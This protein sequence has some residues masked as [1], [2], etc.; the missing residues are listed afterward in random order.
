[1]HRHVPVGIWNRWRHR[2]G[3]DFDNAIFDV[4]FP[5]FSVGIHFGVSPFLLVGLVVA[6]WIFTQWVYRHTIPPVAIWKRTVLKIVRVLSLAVILL[7]LWK[8]VLS[9][10]VEESDAP[11]VAILVD[12]SA[13]MGLEE[14]NGKRSD[15][16]G[17]LFD[18]PL[19]RDLSRRFDLRYF[20]FAD[21][22]RAV[23]LEYVD[24]LQY[25]RTGSNIAGAWNQVEKVLREEYYSA[26][27]VISDGNNNAG[28]NPV[29]QAQYSSVPLFTV[30]IGDTTPARDAMIVQVITNDICYAGDE[31]PV[32]VR[33]RGV[34][35]QG[36]KS[37]LTFSGPAGENLGTQS[38]RW[39]EDYH[40]ETVH[41][42]FT[43]GES[44]TWKYEVLLEPL[45]DEL[46]IHNNRKS[47]Y[48]K[49]LESKVR[50]FVLS[51][52]PSFDLDF[53]IKCLH[54]NPRVSTTLRT[55]RSGGGYYEGA[56]PSVNDLAQ[57]DLMILHHYPTT[58]TNLDDLQKIAEVYKN[59]DIPILFLMGPEVSLR[60][61]DIVS[62]ILPVRPARFSGQTVELSC[63]GAA[64]HLIF[65]DDDGRQW[66]KWEALPPLWGK[67][68][69][70]TVKQGSQVIGLANSQIG[71]G[72][73]PGIVLRKAG[74]K[75]SMAV[76][77]WGLWRWGFLT[78]PEQSKTLE[79]FLDRSI[80]YL[81]TREEDKQVRFTTSKPIYQGGEMVRLSAQ[82]YSED[83]EPVDGAEVE[84]LVTAGE[85]TVR[86][87]MDGEGNGRYS[88]EISA[89]TEGEYTY[90]GKATRD[91][92]LGE[93][94]GKFTVEAFNIEF[95]NT[96]MN[97]QLLRA[98]AT[99]SGGAYYAPEAIGEI[100]E[101]LQFPPRTSTSSWE[102]PIWNRAWLLWVL[103][104][105]LSLEWLIRKRSGML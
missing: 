19:W 37:A 30:G 91:K 48:I 53:F 8:P 72:P 9:I 77:P 20:A 60:K 90:T 11:I 86:L 2:R 13:S 81:V 6:A 66:I 95:L 44:G 15:A 99:L 61:L 92:L 31:V 82:V 51:G 98:V 5:I 32:D 38:V 80:R 45:S 4:M 22:V 96:T 105:L 34:G 70:F 46:T 89:W 55:Q 14:G 35:I 78:S 93:D 79:I 85:E 68:D 49:V 36:E 74:W 40:E 50:V 3:F 67:H 56:F 18:N 23:S 42:T 83:Y 1:M 71:G 59:E 52:A 25:D 76:L 43:P 62:D 63:N 27:V 29:R 103:V 104:G 39:G 88:G 100:A 41:L 12:E 101:R 47:Y 97:Q 69:I 65:Q 24:S 57:L 87:V 17:L 58:G 75:K 102:V 10:F 94:Q 54:E 64:S 28:E 84:V 73:F 33:V 26:A 7:L 16:V 21:S